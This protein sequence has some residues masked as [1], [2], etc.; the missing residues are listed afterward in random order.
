VM[1]HPW[2]PDSAS[3][4]LDALGAPGLDYATATPAGGTART[5]Q[6]LAP[7]FPKHDA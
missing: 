6:R 3:K 2:V 7:L 4:I 5:V 1:L